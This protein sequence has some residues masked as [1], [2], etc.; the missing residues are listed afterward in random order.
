VEKLNQPIKE[1]LPRSKTEMGRAQKHYQRVDLVKEQMTNAA[2]KLFVKKGYNE[3]T[4]DEIAQQIGMSKA[5]LY[6]Y[7]KSKK[8]LTFL[9][10][11]KLNQGHKEFMDAVISM[12]PE[13]SATEKLCEAIRGYALMVDEYQDE[14]IYIY[15]A[16][17]R[18]DRNDR[19][20]FY[21][22]S[23]RLLHFFSELIRL[24]MASR[25]FRVHNAELLGRNIVNAITSW[26]LDRSYWR[27]IIPLE[28]YFAQQTELILR[29]L[30]I[31]M[32]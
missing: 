17:V 13:T 18:L 12:P 9:I 25:E 19:L 14:C 3:T 16:V 26:A 31:D 11:D 4:M 29:Q 2:A 5:N 7:V 15:H 27:K 30:G 8:E 6:N 1:K 32:E 21:D 22:S 24:G 10:L 28:D 23:T 20:K